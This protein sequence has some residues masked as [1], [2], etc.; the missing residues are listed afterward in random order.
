MTPIAN[1]PDG[2][3]NM[4]DRASF[5]AERLLEATRH[6]ADSAIGSV[7]DKVHAVRDRASPALDRWLAPVDALV[8][9][10]QAAPLRSLLLAAAIGASLMA[11]V[12]VFRV[13][14]RR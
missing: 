4:V 1:K 10:T 5:A 14:R 12:G 11:V 8:V 6:T 3:G 13:R 2:A 9:R 7:A